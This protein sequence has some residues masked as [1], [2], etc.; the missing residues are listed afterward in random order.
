VFRH[1]VPRAIATISACV[2]ACALA[3]APPAA[4]VLVYQSTET[5]QG[6]ERHV[7]VAARND[8]SHARVVAGGF[9][10]SVSPDG[11]LVAYFT[12]GRSGI[13]LYVT[14]TEGGATPRLLIH[15]KAY[16]WGYLLLWSPDSRF[17]L[18]PRLSGPGA[19]LVDVR[20]GTRRLTP[21]RQYAGAA[22]SPDGS[23]IVLD[24]A[25]DCDDCSDRL[26]LLRS[27]SL[28]KERTIR[29]FGPAWGARGLAFARRNRIMIVRDIDSQ[30]KTLLSADR[31]VLV[32]VDWS[33][34]GR[35]L[36]AVT[37][38]RFPTATFRGL[39]VRRADGA[40]TEVPYAFRTVVALSRDGRTILGESPGSDVVSVAAD[41][42]ERVL[43]RRARRPSWTK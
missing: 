13:D 42:T 41:G 20:R 35:R 12:T 33:A 39:L 30:P 19:Y 11:R 28:E 24:E 2:L 18:A 32:P 27:G 5:R 14:R 34:S 3:A 26:V 29:G 17:L 38:T 31:E 22:F 36:L 10:P 40:A 21:T 4:A 43:A 6:S 23:R 15:A 7:V 16:H 25:F 1:Q 9:A 37:A 8:G